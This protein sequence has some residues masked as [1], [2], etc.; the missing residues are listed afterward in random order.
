MRPCN[1]ITFYAYYL[2]GLL[3]RFF[4]KYYFK[5]V[6]IMTIKRIITVMLLA[7]FTMALLT[8]KP[9]YAMTD[10]PTLSWED[11][12]DSAIWNTTPR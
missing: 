7:C 12:I 1:V 11:K 10:S 4:I 3:R 6:V 5:E 2:G 9:T 8:A